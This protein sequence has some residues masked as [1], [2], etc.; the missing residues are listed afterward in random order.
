MLGSGRFCATRAR[1]GI[2]FVERDVG[3]TWVVV[4]EHLPNEDEEIKQPPVLECPPDQRSAVSFAECVIGD[5]RMRMTR[6]APGRIGVK[7]GN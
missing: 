7:R 3:A 4:P 5:V 6:I 2:P 1:F